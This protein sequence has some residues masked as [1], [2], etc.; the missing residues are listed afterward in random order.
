MMVIG[1]DALQY[2][3]SMTLTGNEI[4][5]ATHTLAFLF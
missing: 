4:V 3:A 1:P 5:A 2:V